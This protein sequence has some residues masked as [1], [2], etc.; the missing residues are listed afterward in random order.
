MALKALVLLEGRG[1]RVGVKLWYLEVVIG[2]GKVTD[3]CVDQ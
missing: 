2:E 3:C 1:S